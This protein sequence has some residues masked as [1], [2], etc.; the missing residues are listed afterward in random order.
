[1]EHCELTERSARMTQLKFICAEIESLKNSCLSLQGS[2]TLSIKF[3]KMP[4]S[5]G[6]QRCVDTSK[7]SVTMLRQMY[8]RLEKL[9]QNLNSIRLDD[10]FELTK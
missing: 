6:V 3:A 4:N 8:K 2:C 7:E 10:F 1:M 5:F 9:E